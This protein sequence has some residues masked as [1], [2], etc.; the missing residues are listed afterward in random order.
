MAREKRGM[1]AALKPQGL[2]NC[3]DFN[4]QSILTATIPVHAYLEDDDDKP[5]PQGE[6]GKLCL[7]GA[8]DGKRGI[9]REIK[10][11]WDMSLPTERSSLW[12]LPEGK[13]GEHIVATNNS[14]HFSNDPEIL[15]SRSLPL[16]RYADEPSRRSQIHHHPNN[17]GGWVD[18]RVESKVNPQ[19]DSEVKGNGVNIPSRSDSISESESEPEAGWV[20]ESLEQGPESNQGLEPETS[21]RRNPRWRFEEDFALCK[22]GYYCVGLNEAPAGPSPFVFV[23]KIL[24]VDIQSKAFK[25]K[26][27]KCTADPWTQECLR[28]PWHD[29]R[30]EE[31]SNPHYS[32]MYYFKALTK[33]N[34]L[35]AAGVKRISERNIQWYKE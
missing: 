26:P 13:N 7:V 6:W 28:K 4:H 20:D 16:M 33:G 17:S 12:S 15:A 31:D 25:Y 1:V 10:D 35:P 3:M 14:F 5:T 9:L 8:V 21:N 32:V 18:Q 23:G 29:H 11:Y 19:H 22:V 30:M 27:L 34:K 2:L 24:D